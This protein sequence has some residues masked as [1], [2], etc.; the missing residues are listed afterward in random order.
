[1]GF[2]VAAVRQTGSHIRLATRQGGEPHIT[3]TNHDPIKVGALHGILKDVAAR[4]CDIGLH[5]AIGRG[6][7]SA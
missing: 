5:D 7:L 2:C 1:M 6:I 4:W 3:V